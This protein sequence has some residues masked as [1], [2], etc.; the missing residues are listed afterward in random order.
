MA[1]YGLYTIFPS[2][3]I[4]PIILYPEIGVFKRHF[5]LSEYECFV[6]NRSFI[7]QLL[8]FVYKSGDRKTHHIV[9]A[10]IYFFDTYIP[11]KLLYTISACFV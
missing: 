10:A 4:K 9:V 8:D 1:L 11:Y 6:L 7:L 2:D 5:I 3:G